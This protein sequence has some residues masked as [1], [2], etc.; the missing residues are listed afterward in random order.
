MEHESKRKSII[1]MLVKSA[2]TTTEGAVPIYVRI[3]V[4]GKRDGFFMGKKIH[5]DH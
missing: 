3:T 5:P 4:K 1:F 2:K